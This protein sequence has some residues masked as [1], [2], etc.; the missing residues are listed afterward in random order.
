MASSSAIDAN[1]A[2]FTKSAPKARG[3]VDYS[4]TPTITRETSPSCVTTHNDKLSLAQP[5][6]SAT[7]HPPTLT[8]HAQ[9]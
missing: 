8:T 4:I 9:V 7:V 1:E 6:R 3:G 5:V 2:V